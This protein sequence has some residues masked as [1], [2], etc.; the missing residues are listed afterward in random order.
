MDDTIFALASGAGRAGVAVVRASGPLAGP[1]LVALSGALPPPRQ[2][3]LRALK[4][5]DDSLIDRALVMWFPEPSSF[6]GEDVAEF[7]IHGGPAVLQALSDALLAEGL[8]PAEPGEFSRRAFAHGRMD[9]TE[10]EGLADLIDAET[11]AQREQALAQMG[12]ALGSLYG[13]WREALIDTL[14]A[15]EGEIDF[16]DEDDVPEGLSE[17]AGPP[18]QALCAGMR[19]HLADNHRGERVRDGFTIAVIGAPNAGKSSFINYM[20]QRDAAIVSDIPGTTRDIVE[21]RLIRAGFVVYMA[22]TAGLREASDTIEAEGVRRALA[23]AESADMRCLLVDVS[24]ET[25]TGAH[26]AM[27][28][29]GDAVL[30]NKS[31]LAGAPGPVPVGVA[32][33][34]VSVTDATGLDAFNTW[35]DDQLTVRL[36]GAEAAP[37]SRA[38]HRELVQRALASLED[39]LDML[40]SRPELAGAEVNRAI[41]ALGELTGAVDI[42]DVLDRVF[43]QF[44]IGK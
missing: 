5:P 23:R 29:P 30:F 1:A 12:G 34:A 24:R 18:L 35:L 21:V 38:R 37:L 25:L 11:A 28:R 6:T 16:P 41:R 27:L 26:L 13:E 36:G 14:A 3:A 19:A 44:C 9:L 40:S 4:G 33:F 8:R 31:D 32:A 7:H 22:D 43:S 2:A 10:A 17:R 42:E 20:A 15:I 39:A